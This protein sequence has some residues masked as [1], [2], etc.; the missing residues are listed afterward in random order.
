MMKNLRAFIEQGTW[1][2]RSFNAFN[3]LNRSEMKCRKTPYLCRFHTSFVLAY[4]SMF[5]LLTNHL[6]A[7]E[8]QIQ[9][10]LI[11][12]YPISNT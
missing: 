3:D 8:Q 9:Y 2:G 11:I 10:P 5:A 6:K 1:F 4:R 12:T 7:I